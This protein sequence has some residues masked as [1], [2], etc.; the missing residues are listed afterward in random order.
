MEFSAEV[1]SQGIEI[2]RLFG[3]ERFGGVA[4]FS[5]ACGFT[6]ADPVICSIAGPLEPLGVDKGLEQINRVMVD[7][8]PVPGYATAVEGQQMGGQM[9]NPNPGKNQKSTLVRDQMEIF[10]SGLCTPSDKAVPDPNVPWSGRPE[11]TGN[12]PAM[13]KGHV[14][15]MFSNRLA[16]AQI[17]MLANETVAK[18]LLWASADLLKGYGEKGANGA[19]DG[20]LINPNPDRR[21]A[22]GQGIGKPA[23]G[24]R[25]LD[26]PLGFEEQEQAATDH[27]LEG[28]IGLTP[29]PC[30]AHLLGNEPSAPTGMGGNDLSDK[31]N[32]GLGDNPPAI[33]SDDLHDV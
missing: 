28:A 3:Q 25:Q 10:L 33:C 11:Q 24:W 19:M 23:F 5:A 14:L 22:V 2:D 17:V 1:L 31:G 9:G 12:G 32:I 21:L 26:P 20:R 16:I 6:N 18:L 30:P 29:V 4:E 7:P 27:V 8:F 13:G 15:E